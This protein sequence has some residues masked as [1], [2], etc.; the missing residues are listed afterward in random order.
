MWNVEG[1]KLEIFVILFVEYLV[2]VIGVSGFDE[3]DGVW[4][5]VV[6]IEGGVVYVW[7]VLIVVDFGSVKFIVICVEYIG[8]GSKL[9]V[10]VVRCLF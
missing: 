5:V 6:V 10:L 4:R 9:G 2:V 3:D 7:F 8:K 1:G